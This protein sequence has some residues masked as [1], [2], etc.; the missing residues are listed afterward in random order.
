MSHK[1]DN[2]PDIQPQPQSCG[3]ISFNHDT[4]ELHGK[5][6]CD[7]HHRDRDLSPSEIEELKKKYEQLIR[8]ATAARDALVDKVLKLDDLATET[9][10]TAN[11]DEILAALSPYIVSNLTTDLEQFTKSGVYHIVHRLTLP[12]QSIVENTYVLYVLV[13]PNEIVQVLAD[14]NGYKVRVKS[15]DTWEDW[16]DK[17]S[18]VFSEDIERIVKLAKKSIKT[19]KA[20]L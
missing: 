16:S 2:I 4:C 20:A 7:C 18:Y 9:N 8:E 17:H 6:D 13:N 3:D 14:A 11:K 1:I 10:A 5:P 15:S 19:A 12:N